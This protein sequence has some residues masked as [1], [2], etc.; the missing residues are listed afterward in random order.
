MEEVGRER[1]AVYGKREVGDGGRQRSRAE[2][3]SF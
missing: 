1:D 2:R 3:R